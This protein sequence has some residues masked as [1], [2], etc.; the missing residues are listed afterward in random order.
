MKSA[1]VEGRR[2]TVVI[3]ISSA[4]E[5]AKRRFSKKVN[6]LTIQGLNMS[7]SPDASS[8]GSPIVSDAIDPST[9]MCPN[10]GHDRP[11]FPQ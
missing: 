7:P 3:T 6:V 5:F 11:L 1:P 10:D 4:K 2:D 9:H 8:A